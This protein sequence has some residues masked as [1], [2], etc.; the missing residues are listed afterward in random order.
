MGDPNFDYLK[1]KFHVSEDTYKI[2]KN[3]ALIRSLNAGEKLV[4]QGGKSNKVAFL[5]KGLM[6]AY[7]TLESGKEI[8]KNLFT[9][10][11]FVGALSSLIND[12]PST[13]CY[14]ALVDSLIFEINFHEFIEI[15]KHNIDISNLYNRVLEYVFIIYEQKQLHL[16]ALNA[17]DR[18]LD[19]KRRI[20]NIEKLIPQYQIA[21]YLNVS[22]VQLSRIRKALK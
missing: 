2:L 17:T 9:P 11:S 1:S 7:S 3:I 6:R 12:R 21:S 15:S 19:L 18:Y 5:S 10:I 22:P 13:Y 4:E 16:V 20:P 14:E 8:T